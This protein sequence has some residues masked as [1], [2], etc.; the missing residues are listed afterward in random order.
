MQ[1]LHVKLSGWT[2]RWTVWNRCSDMQVDERRKDF[3]IQL[4]SGGYYSFRLG[5]FVAYTC[6]YTYT[7]LYEEL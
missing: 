4:D 3:D 7:F 6:Q 1:V 5:I 2:N